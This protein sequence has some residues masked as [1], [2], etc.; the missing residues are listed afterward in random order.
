M[1]LNVRKPPN[2]LDI[3]VSL[4]QEL[5][6]AAKKRGAQAEISEYEIQQLR[7]SG[8]LELLVPQ[9][10]G[11]TGATW[12]DALKI[13]YELSKAE[14]SIGQLYGNHL[15]LTVLSHLSGTAQ[16]KEKYYRYTARNH[17]LWA[18]AID[19]WD[20][21]LSIIPEGDRFRL[22]GVKR[23]DSL[24][25]AA[26]L[27]VFS[28]WQEGVQQ[29]FFCII[30]KDRLGVT[31][32]WDKIGQERGDSGTFTFHNVLIEKDEI[33]APHHLPNSAFATL[34]GIIAQL[35]KTYVGLGIGQ[36]ALQAI[37][38]ETIRQPN[39]SST[40]DS[41]ALD[42]YTLGNY[43]DVWIELKTA[44]RLAD[45]VAEYLQVAWEKGFQLTHEERQD[46]AN[47]VFSAEVYATRVGLM[48]T[49]RMFEVMGN[50]TTVS[51]RRF[52]RYWQNLH[53]FGGVSMPWHGV[54]QTWT[55]T[56]FPRQQTPC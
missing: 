1:L 11:G 36:G 7:E 51:N 32:D 22:N 37:E 31:S 5:A 12:V 13:V 10:Y 2:Y 45:D 6:Q 39:L 56:H 33:L 41:V 4:S 9:E 46:V 54:P 55:L 16:Q 49:N 42:P 20:T 25:A 47:A 40:V 8:L 17:G 15:N 14:G 35:T 28:A 43:G 19:T 48:I 23:F 50:S 27:R 30:P 29:P 53:T 52:E 24:L 26:D 44:M 38:Q 3:A 34:T 18:S 21:R